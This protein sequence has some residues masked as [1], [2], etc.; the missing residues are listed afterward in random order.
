[1]AK[2]TA[3]IR[4]AGRRIAGSPLATSAEATPLPG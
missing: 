1:M 4:D 2:M 3:S